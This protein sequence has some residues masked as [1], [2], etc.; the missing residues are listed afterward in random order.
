[1]VS[2]VAPSRRRLKVSPE[3]SETLF[4]KLGLHLQD[5]AISMARMIFNQF[6]D[7]LESGKVEKYAGLKVFDDLPLLE[8]AMDPKCRNMLIEAG[9]DTTGSV[10]KSTDRQLMRIEGLNKRRIAAIRQSIDEEQRAYFQW[11]ADFPE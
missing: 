9:F 8:T 6:C 10:R 2:R 11:R 1:M 4:R 5:G 7:E 3:E